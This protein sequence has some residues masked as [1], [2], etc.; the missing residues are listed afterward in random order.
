M[1]VVIIDVANV[2]H[3]KSI[4]TVV[5]HLL[6]GKLKTAS[7]G[8]KFKKEI[9][10]MTDFVNIYNVLE[11]AGRLLNFDDT[12]VDEHEENLKTEIERCCEECPKEC[13]DLHLFSLLKL[14]N[15]GAI[16]TSSDKNMSVCIKKLKDH[17]VDTSLYKQPVIL[18]SDTQYLKAFNRKIL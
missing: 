6:L 10:Y 4:P 8:T 14:T 9:S 7:A 17:T 13:D 1:A 5:N 16:I 12:H 18:K 3:P 15:A 11:S 2:K